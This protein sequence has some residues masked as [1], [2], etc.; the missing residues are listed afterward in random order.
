[1][2]D[3]KRGADT[4]GAHYTL[5]GYGGHFRAVRGFVYDGKGGGTGAA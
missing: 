4:G 3:F 5:A 2:G 1:M